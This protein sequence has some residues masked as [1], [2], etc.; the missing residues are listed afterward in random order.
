MAAQYSVE[1]NGQGGGRVEEIVEP[2]QS[3][4][5]VYKNAEGVEP[6]TAAL[7]HQIKNKS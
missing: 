5:L 1:T 2:A 6:E 3:Q 7:S 4:V